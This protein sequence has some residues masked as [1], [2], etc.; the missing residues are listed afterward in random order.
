MG[1]GVKEKLEYPALFLIIVLIIAL[2]FLC[3][4]FSYHYLF[5]KWLTPNNLQGEVYLILSGL[6]LGL[7]SFS[8][9]IKLCNKLGMREWIEDT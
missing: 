2:S 3:G 9:L 4:W 8:L 6:E 5:L 1:E 7:L